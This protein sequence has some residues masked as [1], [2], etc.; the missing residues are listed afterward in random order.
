MTAR[1]T[2]WWVYVAAI[3]VGL[4]LGVTSIWMLNHFNIT[5]AGTTWFVPL[6]LI[7]MGIAILV[8]AWQVRKY[9]TTPPSKR[10]RTIDPDRS[11]QILVMAKSLALAGALLFGWYA[12]Q[13]LM[14]LPHS[15]A[16]YYQHIVIRCAVTAG[17]SL[18]DMIIGIISE[19]WCQIPPSEGGEHEN[20]EKRRVF[21]AATVAP[22]E[23]AKT[24]E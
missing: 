22:N 3:A 4:L 23:V 17:V 10:T 8:L 1:R 21:N 7:G 13:A 11:V 14:C 24:T 2:P 15:Q 16:E 5:I 12:G 18:I 9:A 20:V 19:S 6:V